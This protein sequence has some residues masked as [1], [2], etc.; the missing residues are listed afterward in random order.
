MPAPQSLRIITLGGFSATPSTGTD[1]LGP[2]KPLA[3]L[4]ILLGAP[5]RTATRSDLI[6]TLWSDV[7]ESQARQS[8]RQCLWQLRQRFGDEILITDGD[9]V[10][11][12]SHVTSDRDDFL[13]ATKAGRWVDAVA[14]HTGPFG[15]LGLRLGAGIEL[16]DW[17]SREAEFIRRRFVDAGSRALPELIESGRVDEALRLAQRLRDADSSNQAAWRTVLDLGATVW[18]PAE[19][20]TEASRFDRFLADEEVPAET[21]SREL[22]ARIGKTAERSTLVGRA[23]IMAKLASARRETERG[24][25]RWVHVVGGAGIGKSRILAEVA[26]VAEAAGASVAT[27]KALLGARDQARSLLVDLV[28]AL[29]GLRGAKGASSA[30][31]ALLDPDANLRGLDRGEP[32]DV[33][34]LVEALRDLVDAIA[35]ERHLVVIIDDLHWSDLF[36]LEV[37]RGLGARLPSGVLLVTAARPQGGS[38]AGPEATVLP[39]EAMSRDDTERLIS[40]LA[41]VPTAG[42]RAPFLEAVHRE[43]AGNPLFVL[44]TIRLVTAE[45]LLVRDDRQWTAPD[46][47]ALIRRIDQGAVI[48]SRLAGRTPFE[49]AVLESLATIGAGL[50]VDAIAAAAE[51]TVDQVRSA[52]LRLESAG[53]VVVQGRVW[54]LSHDVIAEAIVSSIP[55]PVRTAHHVR[56]G[57]YLAANAGSN[58]WLIR[59]AAHH[60]LEGDS[61]PDLKVVWRQWRGAVRRAGDRSQPKQLLDDL[62]GDRVPAAWRRALLPRTRLPWIAAVALVTAV[63]GLFYSTRPHRINV[64]TVPFTGGATLVPAP[65][66]EV[67]DW[68]GRR[69]TPP[70]PMVARLGS[71][72][73]ALVGDSVVPVH[74]G[75]ATFDNLRVVW[76]QDRDSVVELRFASGAL[77][78]PPVRIDLDEWFA[79]GFRLWLSAGNVNGTPVDSTRRVVRV[80]AGRSI[81]GTLRFR[82]RSRS[83]NATT[84]FA[85]TP[86]WGTPR[87]AWTGLLALQTPVLNAPI[88]IDLDLVAPSRPG[89]YRLVFAFGYEANGE[90]LMSASNWAT[91]PIWGDG[92]DLAMLPD[93]LYDEADRTGSVRIPWVFAYERSPASV[94]LTTLVVDVE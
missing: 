7:S 88:T 67:L 14:I 29:R 79:D 40:S 23:E 38:S 45:R 85:Y 59:A 44:E 63:G 28:A 65:E 72:K 94:A 15:A 49:R 17:I 58:L 56:V 8:L 70:A 75:H 55:P 33:P 86:T 32:D 89:R 81:R 90:A 83:V 34:R 19:L 68:W 24:S 13:A 76:G 9:T 41:A 50:S 37:I 25:S 93:S 22:L 27:A 11:L 84:L 61:L 3:L 64:V 57:R 51:S 36:S 2:G 52:L 12:A 66:V 82:Y 39:L 35:T 69:V 43:T 31:V 21:A 53:L 4:V 87:T 78:S 1:A 60:F 71:R 54:L 20:L 26:I 46:P 30:A 42:W 62:L 18:S 92:N 91:R 6:A 74:D 47:D 73:V 5:S 10:T 77:E 16:E 80:D 48:E